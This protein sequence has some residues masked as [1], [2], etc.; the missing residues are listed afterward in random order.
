MYLYMYLREKG[1]HNHV[2]LHMYPRE[3]GQHNHV[4]VLVHI[5][6][7]E[8]RFTILSRDFDMHSSSASYNILCFACGNRVF[9]RKLRL[10]MGF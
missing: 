10:V 8:T 9:P 1:Q 4:L 7:R 6:T 5:S 2:Y 3:K